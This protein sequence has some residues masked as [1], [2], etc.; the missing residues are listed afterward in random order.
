M[1]E[2]QPPPDTRVTPARTVEIS[3]EHAGR[4]LDKYL[5]AELKGVPASLL[6]RLLRKGRVRVNDSRVQPNY[7]LVAGD[8]LA[9]PAMTVP[10]AP[11]PSVPGHLL[12]QIEN[13]VVHEDDA[14][15]IV[16]KPA[17][18][19][20]HVGTGVS[21]GVIEALRQ[22]RPDQPDLELAHRLDRETSGL[23]MVAKTPSMLRH[24][25]Q[26]LRDDG[27]A[28]LG[29]RY[30]AL[31]RGAWPEDHREVDAPLLRTEHSVIVSDA[32]QPARTRFSVRRRFG[33]EATLVRAQ[34]VT[35]RKHQIRVHATHAGH[36]IA[37]DQKH[38]TEPFNQR[39][40]QLGAAHLF[41]HAADLRIPL[42]D[43]STLKVTAP[44]PAAWDRALNRLAG[45]GAD[46]GGRQ[47]AGGGRSRSRGDG[48][49]RPHSSR[50]RG[51]P[52]GQRRSRR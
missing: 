34:L 4:R 49:K 18:V 21:A 24:L 5:R 33:G 40:R 17:D 14:L 47:V 42:P 46:R 13:S 16:N 6:F 39:L 32:G 50:G 43:G 1:T 51:G 27:A 2:Q 29:R 45:H 41:L 37:G 35:G 11:P 25:Q 15:L 38:G 12:R 10:A 19:A 52:G 31:V 44:M 23:L 28:S 20:V 3:A 9:L 22:L 8:R 36:P 48:R 30:L 7:R 26:V